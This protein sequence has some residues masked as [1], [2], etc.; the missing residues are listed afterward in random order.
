MKEK[1]SKKAN[2]EKRRMVF[3]QMGFVI[4][5]GVV[6][7]AFEMGSSIGGVSELTSD[8]DFDIDD[9]IIMQTVQEPEPPQPPPPPPTLSEVMEIVDDEVE[10]LDEMD[11]VDVEVDQEDAVADIDV[12]IEEE[13]DEPILFVLVEKKPLFPGGERGLMKWIA[14]NV[15]YPAVARENGIQGRVYVRFCVSKTGEVNQVSLIRGV[16]PILDREALSVVNK[17]PRWSPGE[18]RQKKVN[19][20]YQVPINFRLQ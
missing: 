12:E 2:L 17:L 6:L 18:Q 7:C 8:A 3:L 9:E 19:V 11:I 10:I 14:K 15:K 16:D 5:L 13:S 4:A 20:W 1:K